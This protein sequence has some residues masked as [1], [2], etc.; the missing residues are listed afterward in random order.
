MNESIPGQKRDP[1]RGRRRAD[2]TER[3][4]QSFHALDVLYVR[5]LGDYVVRKVP[6]KSFRR[7]LI[8]LLVIWEYRMSMPDDCGRAGVFSFAG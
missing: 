3:S 2:S 1:N 4:E 8:A 5:A 7:A 6:S